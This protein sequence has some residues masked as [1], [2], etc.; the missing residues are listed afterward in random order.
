MNKKL[1]LGLMAA[2]TL[3]TPL[4]A[5]EVDE[6]VVSATGIPTPLAQ[7]GAS[8]DIIT[9]ED[10]E[11][12]QITYLQD[13]LKT[14]AGI[15]TYSSGGPGTLSNVFMRG[16]GGKY[17]A[18]YVDGIKINNPLNQSIA[19]SQL[20]AHGLETVE[21]L[22]GAQSVLYGSEAIGGAINIYTAVGGDREFKALA[23]AGSFGTTR[24]VGSAKGEVDDFAYG[25]SI[26]KVT[27]DGFSI[28]STAD[29]NGIPLEDDGHEKTSA[30][31]RVKADISQKLSADIAYRIISS[32]T[33]TDAPGPVDSSTNYADFD[34]SGFNVKVNY[35]QNAIGHSFSYGLTE[36]ENESGSGVEA[37]ERSSL[38][39]RGILDFGDGMSLL[40]GADRDVETY[41]SAANEYE[42]SNVAGYVVM[43]L[44]V[45]GLSTTVAARRDDH[46][47]FGV[48]DTYRI[49]GVLDLDGFS[50]RGTYGTG[51]RAPSLFELY[52]IV[53]MTGN[54]EL[55]PEES[56]GGDVGLVFSA[57][58]DASLE[59]AYFFSTITDLIGFGPDF[60]N[61][62]TTGDSDTSGIEMRGEKVLFDDYMLTGNYT[63]LTAEDAD[64]DRLIRRPRHTLNLNLTTDITERISIAGSLQMVR[65]VVDTD[66]STNTEVKLD[67]Y[68]LVSL[69][70]SYI[71][72]ERIKATARVENLLDED[73]ETVSGYGTAGRAFYVGVSSSF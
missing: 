40:V 70:G 47:E 43:Q 9:A 5:E 34:A 49:S 28:A 32:E 52:D 30:R 56:A 20:P 16:T 57:A 18:A 31:F 53:Y 69:T 62:Q 21:V 45:D 38:G 36:D 59:I 46:E 3:T 58:D 29:A 4:W 61:A 19:W 67:D 50:V 39:Y 13:A 8:V 6:I 35:Q 22:R 15:S 37:G 60:R 12:Q 1:S 63:Y 65:D 51:F 44:Y 26:E 66:F 14:V 54:T 73:Y 55:M 72:N 23:D 64:G 2:L 27:L 41:K 68:N 17:A 24:F 33:D 11:R 7:I 25:A 42:A 71:V 10:I 48:F